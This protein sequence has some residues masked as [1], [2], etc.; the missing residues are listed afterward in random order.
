[1]A[2]GGILRNSLDPGAGTLHAEV[3][4][5]VRRFIVEGNLAPGDRIIERQL[6]GA[7]E[8]S[9]TPLREALKVLAAEGLVD[10]L[11]NRGALVRRMSASEARHLF[12]AFAGLEFA[13]GVLACERI[14][15]DAITEIERLHYAM[16][17]R[18]MRRDIV[19][20]FRLNQAI[21]EAFLRAAESPALE[22]MSRNMSARL[23]QLRF[24]ANQLERDRWGEAMREHEQMLEAL[25]R[26]D[27]DALGRALFEHMRRKC[28]AACEGIAEQSKPE[29][30]HAA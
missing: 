17:E 27:G 5:R 21:H 10:L 29:E 4:V 18:Y 22:A 20:Y 11:P 6:C 23:Q 12:E 24:T 2:D 26:R 19:E 30:V 9:R 7:L 28:A 3:L 13:T 8:V 1:M 15:P 25:Q 16:Y 14:S